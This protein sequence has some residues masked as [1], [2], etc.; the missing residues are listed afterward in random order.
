MIDHSDEESNVT[1]KTGGLAHVE[2]KTF[3]KETYSTFFI[4]AFRGPPATWKFIR[5]WL[6]ALLQPAKIDPMQDCGPGKRFLNDINF[7]QAL[8]SL[9]AAS[10]V[11][12]FVSA[13]VAKETTE[14]RLYDKLIHFMLSAIEYAYLLWLFCSLLTAT[15]LTSRVWAFF[16]GKKAK[17]TDRRVLT[18]LFIYEFAVL[19][20]PLPGILYQHEVVLFVSPARETEEMATLITSLQIYTACIAAHFVLF[21]LCLGRRVGLPWWTT[22]WT[23]LV[24]PYVCLFLMVPA[25]IMALPFYVLPLLLLLYPLYALAR[26]VVP[27]HSAAGRSF[28]WMESVLHPPSE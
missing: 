9:A 25:M 24:V 5:S 6:V 16:A 3:I 1:S 7:A 14:I 23:S 11:V 8:L 27:K 26:D 2:S 19:F 18:T 10:A 17:D 12:G 21:L 13:E 28:L 22:V 15:V 4:P 20:L